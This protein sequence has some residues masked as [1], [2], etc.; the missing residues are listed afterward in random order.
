LKRSTRD[1]IKAQNLHEDLGLSERHAGRLS[2]AVKLIASGFTEGG[3]GYEKRTAG[4]SNIVI[5]DLM[6]DWAKE[7]KQYYGLIA[8][9]EAANMYLF[10]RAAV[11]AC[12]LVTLRYCYDQAC[13][14]WEAIAKDD[15]LSAKDARKRFLIW[16]QKNKER[17]QTT[18]RAFALA[19]KAHLDGREMKLLRFDPSAPLN[20]VGVPLERVSRP[21]NMDAE[22][23]NELRRFRRG[24]DQPDQTV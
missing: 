3:K 20:I 9:G 19:W 18:A 24:R 21:T 15:G 17:P 12:G 8:G 5:S 6:R 14:F 1:A 13:E 10:D 23:L 7:S 22:R 11:I 16:L 2:G 4:R